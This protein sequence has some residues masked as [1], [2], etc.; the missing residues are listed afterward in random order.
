MHTHHLKILSVCTSD[1]FGGAARAAKRIHDG[2]NSLDFGVSSTMLVKY[3][4]SGDSS[5]H[6]L[7]EFIPT[8]IAFK[9]CDWTAKKIKNKIQ[10]YQWSKYPNRE[11]FFM[12]DVRGTFLHGALQKIDFDV[13]HL[14]WVN[15]RFINLSDLLLVNK[16]IVWTL[17]DSWP[18]CGIC[19]YFLD[20]EGYKH[21]CGCCPFLHSD[22]KNDLSH[23]IWNQKSEIFKQLDLH[24]VTPSKWLCECA[25]N[26][27][28]FGSF[29]ITVI[30]NCLDTEIFRPLSINEFSSQWRDLIKNKCKR[31]FL[32]YG[33]MN[34]AT[35][36]IK[37]FSN[38]L[39]ALKILDRQNKTDFELIVFGAD[40]SD[41]KIDIRIPIHFVGTIKNTQHLV[42][43]YNI[44]DVTV[45]PSWTENLS[46][47]IM[48]SMSC[49][50]PVCC[51]DIG[52]N[53]DMVS[54]KNNGYLATEKD[55]DDLANGIDWCMKNNVDNV[56][57]EIGR[58]R[59]LKKYSV[60]IVMK[61]YVQQYK[62]VMS[63]ECGC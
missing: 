54:H 9:V 3:K 62:N 12:S 19:H 13:L 8:N 15:Q 25:R 22:D 11:H 56:L 23:K 31:S 4:N 41:L 27:S 52:G 60:D 57:G 5:I 16:P 6:S 58:Q 53:S 24:I 43:L 28:L 30:P 63:I 29:P 34:A 51:F 40:K 14:H 49:G 46:C 37:G 38:L 45:V 44:A 10:H 7:S 35:D 2:V 17:H 1:T 50:T 42:E 33:A 59:V 21:Q 48:E 18:F 26:S 20:C 55:D 47:T 39:A 61:Q 32:L 36:K